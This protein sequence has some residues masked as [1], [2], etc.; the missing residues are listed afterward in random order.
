V[1]L[2]RGSVLARRRRAEFALFGRCGWAS[3]KLRA[4]LIAVGGLTA[5][6]CS[7][8]PRP[9]VLLVSIDTLRA[10]RTSV[11]RYERDTTP[12]LRSLANAGVKVRTA[13]APSATTAPSHASL[14]TGLYSRAHGVVKNGVVLRDLQP[15][16]AEQLRAAGY[17]TAGFASSFVLHEKF[18]FGRGFEDYVDDFD[19]KT[20]TM[21]PEHW[22]GSDVAGA[23]DRRAS[24][25]TELAIRWLAQRDDER[26]FFLFVHYFDPHSPYS[27]PAPFFARFVSGGDGTE[28]DTHS[29]AY[30]GEIAYTDHQLGVLLA[31]L[32]ALALSDNTLVAVTADHGEAFLEHGILRHGPHL[33][34]E[35][36]RIPLVFRWPAGLPAG[37]EVSGLVSLVD[38]APT[39]LDL[40][41][42]GVTSI[43]GHGSSI[44][45]ALRG[46]ERIPRQR[47][48]FLERRQYNEASVQ[49]LLVRGSKAAIR[50]GRWKYIEAPSEGSR[51][52]YDLKADPGET[53]SL[54]YKAPEKATELRELLE[55]W[56]ALPVN[57]AADEEVS[58]EDREALRAL[59]YV[60]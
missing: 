37:L 43:E 20:S 10:D 27:S 18:G 15:T 44:A 53:E 32:D 59:G 25:T 5:L 51:E 13:Y 11:G 23:F 48:V 24:D 45:Q 40:L 52:L 4:V 1:Q 39:L 42:L 31:E 30:D 36:V 3:T 2:V 34:D 6:A 21:D 33:Y 46:K 56:L 49:G 17:Q 41:G 54:L 22:E 55:A 47:P 28:L 60:D 12:T 38:V 57:T 50:A 35:A 58:S 9:N 19:A 8:E 26:P 29:R 14:F 7:S 16:L